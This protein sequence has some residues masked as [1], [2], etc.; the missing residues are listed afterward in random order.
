MRLS[1]L[2]LAALLVLAA[3]PAAAMQIFVK[4]P[5]GRTVTL[6]VEAN[7]TIENVKAKIQD[8]EGIPSSD[9]RLI[10]AG[11]EMEDDRTLAD[12]NVQKESTLHLERLSQ[13]P[14]V[15]WGFNGDGRATPPIG[16]SDV[17]AVST[18]FHSLALKADGTVVAWGDNRFDQ[19]TVPHGLADVADVSAGGYHNLA[20]KADGTVIAWG[21]DDHGQATVPDGLTDVTAVSA[22][23]LHSIA[24]RTDGTVVVWGSKA[25]SR[26]AV[27]DGLAAIAAVS[28]GVD[29][30]LALRADGTVVAWGDNRFD[31]TTVPHG[32]TGVTAVAAGYTHS[33]ALKA[34]GTVV[35][36]GSDS[37]ATVPDGLTDVTAVSAGAYH[38]L[39]LKADGTVVAWGV[40][41]AGQAAVPDGLASVTAISAGFFHNFALRG[42]AP[43]DTPVPAPVP[44]VSFEFA[45]VTA[46]E[47]GGAVAI[48]L[49]LSEPLDAP[50]E[51]TLTLAAGDPADLGGFTFATVALPTG[52]VRVVVEVPVTD[53]RLA[54]G[55]ESFRFALSGAAGNG[56]V[57]LGI[58]RSRLT[59]V[60]SDDDTGGGSGDPGT[61]SV[62]VALPTSDADGDGAEDG[63]PRFLALPVAGVTAGALAQAAAGAGPAPTVFVLDP[64]GELVAAAPALVLGV[65]QPVYVDV[66][67]GADLSVVGGAA[68]GTVAFPAAAVA[69]R[70]LVAVGNPTAAPVPLDALLVR[71]GMLAET[72]LVFDPALG[73]F[74]PAP[75]GERGGVLAPFGAVVVQ[76]VP[77]GDADDVFVYLDPSAAEPGLA[78]G[79]APACA[80]G[81]VCL[82]LRRAG[83]AAGDAVVVR[84]RDD[85]GAAFD[86][87]DVP[88]P[89]GVRL[90]L[91]GGAG[92]P[93]A[94]W[95][96]ALG[97]GVAVPLDVAV[98]A[99]GAYT[100]SVEAAA[101]ARRR[102]PDVRV[103]VVD[104]GGEVDLGEP[105]A[106]EVAPGEDLSGRF[107]L[108]I[109]PRLAVAIDD[110]PALDRVGVP[111]PNPTAGGAALDVAVAEVQHVRVA[112]YDALGRTVAVA[113]DGE[114]RPGAPARVALG[115][116]GLAPGAYVVRVDGATVRE[117]RRLTV[118][119]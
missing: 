57:G 46:R 107:A 117:V 29:H 98:G 22:G 97:D 87:V 77:D 91:A 101:A 33:L 51:V 92:T 85:A 52:A 72:A 18:G 81:D 58:G 82:A 44:E 31:Q 40:N 41:D 1:S 114:V 116:A 20:L 90:S 115:G 78:T 80:A 32:L 56:E 62:A 25:Y 21:N 9:Q 38:S 50:A 7:D 110:R 39:A 27:P 73:A 96:T 3:G 12:Y 30:S 10:F 100:L 45:Q 34:D 109:V 47:G 105:Y 118:T 108:R 53:D 83:G 55:D 84:L 13:L 102:G 15:G 70:A 17:A 48:A 60:V 37:Q 11:K 24:L 67:P 79:L 64:A 113:L 106:F 86:A 99:A 76:V 94:A 69:G 112:V 19:T 63:G 54:E 2:A 74:R 59:L 26:T 36:W 43:P 95:A 35:A 5:D 16:L 89:A 8:K 68:R 14:L 61:G 4:A 65:G 42:L 49:V 71:G 23:F 103:A 111:F 104:R 119:R 28:A 93:L 88:S 66:A 75:R 6:D